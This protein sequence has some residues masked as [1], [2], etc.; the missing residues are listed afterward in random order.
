M[1]TEDAFPKKQVDNLNSG[2]DK[3]PSSDS[4]SCDGTGNS[5]DWR[6][7]PRERWHERAIRYVAYFFILVSLLYLAEQFCRVHRLHFFSPIIGD[8]GLLKDFFSPCLWATYVAFGLVIAGVVIYQFIRYRF[9]EHNERLED[10]SEVIAL[11][12]D[13]DNIEPRLTEPKKKPEDFQRKKEKAEAEQK[14]LKKLGEEGWTEYRVLPLHQLLVDFLKVDDLIANA[15]LSLTELEE[16]AEDDALP[17]DR[18]PYYERKN[19]IED[20]IENIREVDR[21]R[22]E[23]TEKNDTS[24]D[25]V[26]LM[27]DNAA[28]PLRA[29]YCTLLD[30][31]ASYDKSWAAGLA[32]IRGI[33]LC[34]IPGVVI[35][36]TMG[37]LPILHVRG[38]HI[39]YIYNWGLLGSAGAVAGV[40][41]AL[42]KSNLVLVG[43]TE[44]KRE[45]WRAILSVPL[46]LLAGICAYSLIASG[47]LPSG[48]LVPEI[49]FDREHVVQ[50]SIQSRMP[51]ICLSIIWAIGS[52]ICFEKVFDHMIVNTW[53]ERS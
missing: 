38:D 46:G 24:T 48:G 7:P 28:E 14:V 32:V 20:A 30:H 8:S 53:G 15:R 50:I 42:R 49:Y 52:G 27:K 10:P 47:L 45:L 17:Y 23:E 16:Y 19:L 39:L 25:N 4:D 9:L 51:Q 12:T 37:L 6:F 40:L 13:V 22:S 2:V 29:E 34:G 5:R 3:P 43:Y 41:L 1:S 11:F 36:T 21:G 35:L 33:M 44:G 31:V 26:K 18:E